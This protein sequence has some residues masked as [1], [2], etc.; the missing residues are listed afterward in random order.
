M[1]EGCIESSWAHS[2]SGPPRRTYL[3]TEQG[4]RWLRSWVVAMEASHRWTSMFLRRYRRS[5]P[6]LHLA[7]D[8]ALVPITA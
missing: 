2:R 8:D 7:G 1:E 6:S 3:L 4:A 5:E